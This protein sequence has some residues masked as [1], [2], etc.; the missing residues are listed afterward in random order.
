MSNIY[1][2]L[3]LLGLSF[4]IILALE[5]SGKIKVER[6]FI[7]LIFRTEKGKRFISKLAKYRGFWKLFGYLGIIVGFIGM[8]LVIYSLLL[9]LHSKY[10]IGVNM[11]GVKAVIP[12]VTI[13]FWY[14]IIGLITVLVVHE[15]A[16]GILAKSEGISL[17]SLGIVSLSIIPIGAF[18]EPNEDEMK[19]KSRGSRLRVYS[20][21]SFANIIL[22]I[23]A[24]G[25]LTLLS[26]IIFDYSKVQ[27]SEVSDSSPA[28]EYLEVGMVIERINGNSVTS[29]DEFF[30][31]MTGI[32][33]NDSVQIYTDS[34]VFSII[35]TKREDDSSRGFIGVVVT[36]SLE[37]DIT[38]IFGKSLP[39]VLYFSLYWIFFLNQ[40]IGLIN[41]APIHLGIAAT[42]GHHMLKEIFSGV[43]KEKDAEKLS[44]FV[45]SITL[46]A[47]LFTIIDI[48]KGLF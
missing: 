17:K 43:I 26:G 6:H 15:F 42:D 19:S 48:R 23:L 20:A 11:V 3:L 29:L 5:K 27:I 14:G 36:N 39:L 2:L 45:S 28:S 16:H 13:P 24:L 46:L 10:I 4:L 41:L 21:G 34:G 33:P 31:I 8:I 25:G 18:V 32:K 12:G 38:N 40:G 44:Y 22:A 1:L 30:E 7:L 47:I 35:A 9:T 37:K